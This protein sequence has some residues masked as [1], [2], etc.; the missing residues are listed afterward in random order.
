VSGAGKVGAGRGACCGAGCWDPNGCSSIRGK[1]RCKWLA[2][3]ACGNSC[4]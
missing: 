1:A 2:V 4:V 3:C